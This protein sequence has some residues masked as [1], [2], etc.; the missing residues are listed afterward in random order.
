MTRKHSNT[1]RFTLLAIGA[2][3]S[4]LALVAF[5]GT[6]WFASTCLDESIVGDI[7]FWEILAVSFGGFA[8]ILL[9]RPLIPPS[10]SQGNTPSFSSQGSSACDRHDSRSQSYPSSVAEASAATPSDATATDPHPASQNTARWRQLYDQLSVEE[11]RIFKAT[12]RRYCN[13]GGKRGE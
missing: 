5:S 10:S 7:T 11:R 13:D 9:V 3:A 12:M 6:C 4:A 8:A 1:T 2:G